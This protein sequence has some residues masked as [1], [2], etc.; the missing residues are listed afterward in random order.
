MIL[1]PDGSEIPT[2]Y[3]PEGTGGPE[4]TV[5]YPA[6]LTI[7]PFYSRDFPYG[8]NYQWMAS[9]QHQVTRTL[10]LEGQYLGSRTNHLLGFRQYELR[11]ARAGTGS[12]A[13]AG[14]ELC[15]DPGPAHGLDA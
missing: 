8:I 4:A 15:P 10:G 14:S 6:P 9:L 1:L 7:F 11:S 2:D 3:N 13:S 12:R 5:R